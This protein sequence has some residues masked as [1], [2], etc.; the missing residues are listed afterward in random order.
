MSLEI[1]LLVHIC[2]KKYAEQ[3]ALNSLEMGSWLHWSVKHTSHPPAFTYAHFA[4]CKAVCLDLCL[5]RADIPC[6]GSGCVTM[7]AQHL[8]CTISREILC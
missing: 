2:V 3:K 8:A 5:I 4:T 1:H 7:L 6:L